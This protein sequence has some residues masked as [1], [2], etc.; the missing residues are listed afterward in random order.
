MK[1][2]EKGKLSRKVTVRFT[3]VEYKKIYTG[4]KST[5]KR[6]LSEYIRSVL[7]NKPVTVYTR[8]Q[9]FDDF[10]AELILLR[11][12]LNAIGNNFNQSVKKLNAMDDKAEIKLW[13]MLNE[14]S[15]PILFKKIEDVNEK[16]AQISDKWLHE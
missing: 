7:L 2:E 4:F 11:R 1:Q 12:E 15:K 8:N 10:V 9:S 6:K 3:E 14:K 13:A 16:L 5:T